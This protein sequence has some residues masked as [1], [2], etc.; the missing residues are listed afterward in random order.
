MKAY[1][2]TVFL[3]SAIDEER[4]GWEKGIVIAENYVDAVCRLEERYFDCHFDSIEIEEK[5]D[6]KDNIIL[7]DTNIS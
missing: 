6:F 3:S 1:E 7:L 2:Y 5:A 4:L